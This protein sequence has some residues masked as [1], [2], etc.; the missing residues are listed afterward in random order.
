[1]SWTAE[2][3]MALAP[4]AS[5]AK[6]GKGLSAPR[7]WLTLGAS[8]TCAWGTLQGSGKDPYQTSI[9]FSG[10]AFKCTC[11]SRKFP[12]KHGLG[13]FLIVA[14]RREELTE[15][16]APPWTTEWM[17][18]R[19]EKEGKKT[20]QTAEPPKPQDP[21]AE[22]RAAMA[23]EKRAASR[24]SRVA[25]GLDELGI[26]LGD[27]VRNGFAALPGK[28]SSFWQTPAARL[29]DAQAPGLAGRVSALDGITAMGENWPSRLLREAALLHLAQQGWSRLAS[30][31]EPT[32]ADLR[33]VVGFTTSQEEV[34]AQAGVRDLWQVMAQHVEADERLKTHRTWLYGAETKRFALNLSFSAGPNQPLDITLAP[35][36]SFAGELV[37]FPGAWPV[38][39]LVKHRDKGADPASFL[40][41][42]ANIAEAMAMAVNALT[43]NPWCGRIPFA[44][45][46]VTPI[47]RVSGWIARDETGNSLPLKIPEAEGWKLAALAGGHRISLAGEWDGEQLRPLSVQAEGRFLRL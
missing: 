3:V 9:D 33:S 46:A 23:A 28:S 37:F 45:A 10:P 19:L 42:H 6:S 25:T 5:S 15:K 13:L 12:C 36:S 38:R 30:L 17:A 40:W 4:D 26:W 35:G 14:Q 16:R 22:K 20:A 47:Q 18:K 2:Q 44:L 39:A 43:A 1:M 31:P 41:P 34:L 24:E 27:L 7:Q 11:P 21:E 29:V 32:Q 8:E